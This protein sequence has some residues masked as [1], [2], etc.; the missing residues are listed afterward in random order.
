MTLKIGI[1]GCGRMGERHASAY[2]QIHDAEVIGFAD[3]SNEISNILAKKFAKKNYSIDEML[4]DSKIDAV[5][6]CTPNNLHFE[7]SIA[8]MQHGKHVLVEKPM[9]LT[10]SDCDKMIAE[11]IKSKVNLMVGHTYRYY[12]SSLKAKEIIDSGSIGEVKLVLGHSLDPGQLSDKSKTPDWALNSEMGGGVFFDAVHGVDLFRFWFNSEVSKV[13]VPMM[14]KIFDKYSAEQ[15]G[16]A[17]LIFKNGIS[18][19]IMP[20]APTWGIRDAGTKIIGTKGALYVTYG[21]EVKVGKENWEDHPF[22]YQSKPPN[23]EHNLQG[24][25]NEISEFISSI[26]EKRNPQTSGEE[27]RKNLQVVLA[28][29][30]SFQK[31]GIVEV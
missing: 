16:M 15:M 30:D 28:M 25:I 22:D 10:L 1:I 2:Q 7:N 6:I 13:F 20:V 3:K 23:Y 14:D 24:F 8:V 5:H 31:K 11:S 29:Y 19:T 18:A 12:P 17:T 21:E 9:A 26:K 27:G 4:N